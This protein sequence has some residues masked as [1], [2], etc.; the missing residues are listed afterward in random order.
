MGFGGEIA[1]EVDVDTVVTGE[2]NGDPMARSGLGDFKTTSA[3]LVATWDVSITFGDD[4]DET[5]VSEER[6]ES[7]GDDAEET[8]VGVAGDA[9]RG[10]D[11]VELEPLSCCICPKSCSLYLFND[12]AKRCGVGEPTRGTGD[13]D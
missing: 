8:S 7:S 13:A 11:V 6:V 9:I 5:V 4:A 10:D 1:A 2:S 12:G 3:A